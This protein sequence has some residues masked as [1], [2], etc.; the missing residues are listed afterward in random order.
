MDNTKF[1]ELV[2]ATRNCDIVVE[3]VGNLTTAKHARAC[4]EKVCVNVPYAGIAV[5]FTPFNPFWEAVATLAFVSAA[6]PPLVPLFV[7][8]VDVN[9]TS[10]R[11][12][13]MRGAPV[14]SAVAGVH[15]A[16]TY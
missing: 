12:H 3:T 7:Q 4:V 9:P 1:H 10:P 11:N 6:D 14:V 5:K 16:A 2:M 15:A 8:D 13:V